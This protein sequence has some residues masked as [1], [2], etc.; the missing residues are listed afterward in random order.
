MKSFRNILCVVANAA[1]SEPALRRAVALAEA[2]QAR[3][4]VIT[5]LPLARMAH[6]WPAAQRAEED[7]EQSLRREHLRE[8][9]LLTAPHADRVAVAHDVLFGTCFLE[10]IKLVLAQG[11]DLLVKTAENPSFIQRLF[12][13]NDMQLLRECPCA[14]W[15]THPEEKADY[16]SIVAAA[17]FDADVPGEHEAELNAQILELASAVALFDPADLH[18][19]H[20]WDAPAEMMLR[21]WSS[22]PVADSA[23]YAQAV[24]SGSEKGM[25]QL[26]QALRA[27]L[28]DEAYDY[29]APDFHLVRGSPST[30]IPT[31]AH[32]L[33]ADLVVMGTVG[34]SGIAGLF[35]GNTAEM[36]LEQV[37]C[38]VLAVK[39][40]GFVS[41]VRL[42]A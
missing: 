41:P 17:D 14:V 10:V 9:E 22:N 8:L 23:S 39:P 12:G 20:V 29:L 5:V 37:Q 13:S 26:A 1:Q 35:I 2:N 30:M 16:E 31:M 32:Q 28:G 27:L 11:H 15:L 7:L 36:V 38:S 40:P 24:R 4:T 3:L 21:H 6:A 33:D 34:R 25:Q 42:D 18:I 19:L